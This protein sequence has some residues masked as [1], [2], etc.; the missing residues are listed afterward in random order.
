MPARNRKLSERQ[1]KKLEEYRQR[2]LA[3]RDQL[4]QTLAGQL[5]N[6]PSAQGEALGEL[7]D[8]A[9][10]FGTQEMTYRTVEIAGRELALI[11]RAFQKIAQG[12]YGRCE[13]CGRQIPA[14]RLEALPH[15]PYCIACQRLLESSGASNDRLD[16]RWERVFEME[17][18]ENEPDVD[19]TE[20]EADI[21]S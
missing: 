15:A 13:N 12:R 18:A 8:A 16:A 14:A 7:A 21:E 1:R 3:R 20:L 4:R 5:Q 2:L 17:R 6:L 9:L 10:D 11:E 19:L